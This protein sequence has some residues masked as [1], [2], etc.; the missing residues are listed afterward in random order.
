[1]KNFN[2]EE[3]E[4]LIKKTFGESNK[5]ED[6]LKEFLGP[7]HTA[8]AMRHTEEYRKMKE[9]GRHDEAELYFNKIKAEYGG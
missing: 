5:L 6:K 4:S 8:E 9:D 7:K 3:L 1:M 2:T